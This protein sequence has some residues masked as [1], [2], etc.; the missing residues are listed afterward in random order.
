MPVSPMRFTLTGRWAEY[1]RK[2]S[3]ARF[4]R[5]L[6]KTVPKALDLAGF[7][8]RK[9]MRHSM[10]SGKFKR[11]AALTITIKGSTKPLIDF[12][13]MFAAVTH[14]VNRATGREVFIGVLHTAKSRDGKSLTN[15]GYHLHEGVRIPVTAKM[16]R[17]FFYLALASEGTVSP[18]DLTGRAAVLFKRNQNWLPL[19]DT[20]THIVIPGR[21]WIRR[22]FDQK[23]FH[24]KFRIELQNA[25][26]RA[27]LMTR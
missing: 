22:S 13:D 27:I 25:V 12:G 21:P 23:S 18:S 24:V 6:N 19:K 26:K 4:N 15:I 3:P 7:E 11:N 14:V 17:M 16:R 8:M 9:V 1:G 2:L 20:T 10:S 5:A